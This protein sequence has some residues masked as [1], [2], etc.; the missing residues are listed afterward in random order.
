[1][2]KGP[3][4]AREHLILSTIRPLN[5]A[6]K[7]PNPGSVLEYTHQQTHRPTT[8]IL[9]GFAYLPLPRLS[10]FGCRCYGFSLLV[11]L[12]FRLFFR[13]LEGE[14]GPT[15]FFTAKLSLMLATFSSVRIVVICSSNVISDE[16]IRN[17]HPKDFPFG[18]L[19]TKFEI[20]Q[21][22]F[23][24]RQMKGRLWSWMEL[25]LALQMKDN[26]FGE[27]HTWDHNESGFLL[28]LSMFCQILFVF[29][30][31]MDRLIEFFPHP[32]RIIDMSSIDDAPKNLQH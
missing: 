19:G 15:N 2:R 13:I 23:F 27:P 10:S 24:S 21:N 12:G 4:G 1:M 26:Q 28:S 7:S 32:F 29:R 6:S 20:S 8:E 3:R 16:L 9:K 22:R 11:Y 30:E 5:I 14:S 17:R 18:S 25:V 31:S